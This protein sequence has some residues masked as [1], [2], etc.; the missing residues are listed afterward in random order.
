[1]RLACPL[2]LASTSERR[3]ELLSTLETPFQVKPPLFKE[4]EIPGLSPREEARHLA[5][6][7]AMSLV[8]RFPHAWILACDTLVEF[9]GQK[10]GKPQS[11][12]HA[13]EMLQASSGKIQTV[14]TALA[15]YQGINPKGLDKSWQRWE[16]VSEV[17][18]RSFTKEESIAYVET[19]EPMG[20][21]GACALQGLGAGLI[22]EVRG[23]P[24]N[25]VGLPLKKL[26]LILAFLNS[27]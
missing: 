1:M 3:R 16:E 22:S 11:K 8:P 24:D 10:W 15:L 4:R 13:L 19:G 17:R 26:R 5:Y 18:F 20:K 9:Q 6:H 21:A 14:W 23:D 25:V 12:K 7:K 27:F 2:I